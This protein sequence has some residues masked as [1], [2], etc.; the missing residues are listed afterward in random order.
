MKK[1]KTALKIYIIWALAVIFLVDSIVRSLRSNFNF[2]LLLVYLLTGGLWVY[3]LFHEP[4]DAFCAAGIGRVLR[5]LFFCGVGIFCALLAFVAVSGY[6]NQPRG[7]ERAVMILGGG[8]HGDRISGVLRRRLDAAWGYIQQHPEVYIVTTGG[9]GRGETMPEAR[10]MKQYLVE[11]GASPDRI[12]TDE[13][14]TSTEENLLY[15]KQLL[16]S[17]GVDASQPVVVV[18]NAFHCYRAGCYARLVGFGQ[19]RTLPASIALGA[20]MP[21]YFREVFAVL[22]Y[23]VFKSSRS[24]W[25]HPFVGMLSIFKI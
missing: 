3:A 10:A 24:G 15:A 14:S 9:Q 18:T 16:E 22:Y 13:L 23:W 2:G 11:K 8:L 25:M 6:S 5:N 12:L 7:D 1:G 21:C 4:I 19:A 17:V 20:A